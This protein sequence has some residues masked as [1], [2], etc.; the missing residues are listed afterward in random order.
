LSVAAFLFLTGF[1]LLCYCPGWFALA[2]AFAAIAAWFGTER[3]RF[4]A[5][6]CLVVSLIMTGFNFYL[7][8]EEHMHSVKRR[9]MWEQR[10][11]GGSI[12]PELTNSAAT[13]IPHLA[14]PVPHT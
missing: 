12:Q 3:T 14:A 6:A 10:K 4:W 7:D 5:M 9:Q 8:S 2:S 11:H 13:N 1:G